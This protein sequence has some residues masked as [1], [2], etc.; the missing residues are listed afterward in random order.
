MAKLLLVEIV[1]SW[2]F[3]VRPPYLSGGGRSLPYPPPT[4][5]IGS[6]AYPYLKL[7]N[8]R[9]IEY[10]GDKPYSPAVKLLN[11]VKYAVLGYLQP[12][13]TDIVDISK[14]YTYAYL[15]S[16][17]KK[18]RSFWSSAIGVGKTY[19]PTHGVIA[20]I[21]DDNEANKLYEAAWGI[22]RIG[23]KEGLVA[24]RNVRLASLEI[25]DDKGIVETIFPVDAAYAECI[26]NCEKTYMWRIDRE[27]YGP[28]KKNYTELLIEYLVPRQP[29][30]NYGGKMKIKPG[31]ETLR[32][33]TVYGPLILPRKILG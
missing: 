1:F 18:D 31:E 27:A 21:V 28:N 26:E 19:S 32:L 25:L 10:I 22:T 20:Y 23:S 24:V 12:S 2:G 17:Y 5:L 8:P 3:M 6:L 11:T 15:R 13:T 30:K 16:K 33:N 9:E 14:Q 4:T 29:M 7:K